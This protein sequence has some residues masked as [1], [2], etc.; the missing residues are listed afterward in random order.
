LCASILRQ[1]ESDDAIL[2]QYLARIENIRLKRAFAAAIKMDQAPRTRK[3]KNDTED[4]GGLWR[5]LEPRGSVQS[6]VC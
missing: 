3:R 6:S 2:R 1:N 4:D 5:G